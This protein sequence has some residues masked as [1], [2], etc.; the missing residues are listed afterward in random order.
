MRHVLPAVV[1]AFAALL[2]ASQ[3]DALPSPSLLSIAP[4]TGPTAGGSQ[5][6]AEGIGFSGSTV[7]PFV[8][9]QA[10][11]GVSVFNDTELT[12]FLPAYDGGSRLNLPVFVRVDGAPSNPIFG[13]SYDAPVITGASLVGQALTLT[14]SRFGSDTG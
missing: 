2:P 12:F 8:D 11:S 9:G 5:I 1:L 6:T 3:A 7:V 4:S 10:G 13:F 14:G